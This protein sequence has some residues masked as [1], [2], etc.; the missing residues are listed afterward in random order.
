M[1]YLGVRAWLVPGAGGVKD[2]T[3]WQPGGLS[4]GHMPGG[5]GPIT[6][7]ERC[8]SPARFSGLC[9]VSPAA[10]APGTC[11]VAGP[12]H[13]S[14]LPGVTSPRH[15]AWPVPREILRCAQDDRRAGADCWRVDQVNSSN[16]ITPGHAPRR[17]DPRATRTGTYHGAGTF[18]PPIPGSTTAEDPPHA[19]HSTTPRARIPAVC[20]ITTANAWSHPDPPC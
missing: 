15:D 17:G 20:T 6:G 1:N 3:P 18:P 2:H 4:P 12:T 9:V 11:R 16:S 5:G 13:H 10:S 19:S 7:C 14:S 8:L